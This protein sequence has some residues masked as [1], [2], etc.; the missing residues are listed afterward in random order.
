MNQSIEHNP[1]VVTNSIYFCAENAQLKRYYTEFNELREFYLALSNFIQRLGEDAKDEYW[2]PFIWNLR[3]Y[4]ILLSTLPL[5]CNHS[6]VYQPGTI[7][8]L[9]EQLRNSLLV[10]GAYAT[11]AGDLLRRYSELVKQN[12]NHL[13]DGLLKTG[14]LDQPGAKALLLRKS[15]FSGI[16]EKFLAE[17]GINNIDVISPQRLLINACYEQLIIFGASSW[18]PE[19]VFTS[20]RAN[21][22][23]MLRYNWIRD[24]WKP[25]AAFINSGNK[26]TTSIFTR[27]IKDNSST[28]DYTT[29]ASQ[30]AEELIPE[31]NWDYIHKVF[32]RNTS[33]DV[34]D[35]VNAKLFFLEG[36]VSVFLET[37]DKSKQ[38]V[39]N[40]FEEADAKNKRIS[41]LQSILTN[42]L[43]PEMFIVLRTSESEDYLVPMADK[44]LGKNAARFRQYQKHW[45]KLLL[46]KI[47]EK[48]L[49]EI[50]IDLLDLG[51]NRAEENNLRNWVSSRNISPHDKQDFIAIMELTG[52]SELTDLYWD[53]AVKIRSA[54]MRAGFRIRK[55]LLRQIETSDLATLEK[56]GKMDFELAGSGA[57]SLTA[58]RI[59]AVSS[60]YY[61]IPAAQ[62]GRLLKDYEMIWQ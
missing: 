9:E 52:L 29:T 30:L 60:E 57:G 44:F 34:I 50:S 35:T 4:Y 18:Y 14:L 12:T 37:S 53:S 58:F 51:S 42:S 5:P 43:E 46:E 31:I 7:E 22:Y 59:T 47:Q 20:P 48:S 54:H 10:Y 6:S 27:E 13:L 19:Y 3:R 55:L 61:N 33:S 25:E 11:D 36:D 32:T 23:H 15:S 28:K 16:V 41:P 56:L 8:K 24:N 2:F 49:L 21:V 62:T 17:Q 26:S 38:W 1:L 39:I 45:K 40:P